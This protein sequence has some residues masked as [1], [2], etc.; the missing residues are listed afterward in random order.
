M[1]K[2][3]NKI[4]QIDTQKLNQSKEEKATKPKHKVSKKVTNSIITNFQ[5]LSPRPMNKFGNCKQG[6]FSL[7]KTNGYPNKIKNNNM[8]E[9][10]KTSNLQEINWPKTQYQKKIIYL[11]MR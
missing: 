4:P 9:W 10:P 8:G 3:R 1:S 2:N 7:L 6:Y 5:D 11:C